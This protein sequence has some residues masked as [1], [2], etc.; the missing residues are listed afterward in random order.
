MALIGALSISGIPPFNGFFSKWMIYQGL[1]EKTALLSAGYQLW[2]LICIILALFGSA[3]TLASFMK[4]IHAVFLGKKPQNLA[5]VKETS[6]NQWL[7]TGILSTLC[8]VFGIFAMPIPVNTFIAPVL[9]EFGWT[10]PGFTGL[11]NPQLLVVMLLLAFGLGIGIYALL[12][13]VRFDDVYL[14]GMDPSDQFRIAGT[15]FYNEIRNMF[16]L[17]AIFKAAENKYFDM[18]N[19]GGNSTFG[20][21]RFFQKAHPGQLQL[22]VLYIVLGML[23]FI[24]LVI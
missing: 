2:M 20:L 6:F 11:Y 23:L 19:I 12:K 18:Y 1:L 10:L 14:G 8:I 13:K 21:A 22:Y 4:F 16:P 24:W 9:Q 7:A 15:G 5:E 3:L 17:N